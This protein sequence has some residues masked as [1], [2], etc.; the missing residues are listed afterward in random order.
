MLMAQ[1]STLLADDRFFHSL[2][3][4]HC[5][6]HAACDIRP[7]ALDIFTNAHYITLSSYHSSC[8]CIISLLGQPARLMPPPAAPRVAAKHGC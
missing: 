6:V 3:A 2:H 8:C 7:P 5:A 4:R 1:L